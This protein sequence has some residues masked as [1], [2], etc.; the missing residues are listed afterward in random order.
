MY[1]YIENLTV[2]TICLNTDSIQV[3]LRQAEKYSISLT[4]HFNITYDGKEQK[5]A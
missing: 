3:L 1:T 5:E 4:E 2:F